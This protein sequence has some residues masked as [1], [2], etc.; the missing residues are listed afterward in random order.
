MWMSLKAAEVTACLMEMALQA[1]CSVTFL[2]LTVL[3]QTQACCLAL[4]LPWLCAVL[5]DSWDSWD[6]IAFFTPIYNNLCSAA[7]TLEELSFCSL[8]KHEIPLKTMVNGK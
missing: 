6:F 2:Q 5:P 1:W 3:L 4:G 7:Q 8:E